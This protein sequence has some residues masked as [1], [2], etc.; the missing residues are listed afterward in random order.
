MIPLIVREV[1]LVTRRAAWPVAIVIHAAAAALFV[2][3]WGPTGGVPLWQSSVV[4]QL[5]A[6]DR[7]IAAI[8]LTWVA[9]FVLSDDETG[10]RDLRDWSV[11]TGRPA[12]EIFR[13]R[14]AA[15]LMLSL[16]FTASA[17]PAFVAAGEF[18]AAPAGDVAAHVGAALGFACFALG[19]T[20][21]ASAALGNRVAAWTTAMSICVAA[22]F[23]IRMLDTLTMRIAVPAVAGLL[24]MGASPLGIRSTDAPR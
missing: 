4:Q 21:V 17:V 2:G 6:V 20:T 1:H 3:V 12:R 15:A 23:G 19:A 16:V 24:L 13:T 22:A 14:I 18:A 7:L 11:L 5:A 9:T 10:V 8:L